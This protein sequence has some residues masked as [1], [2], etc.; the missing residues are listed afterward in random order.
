MPS[1]AVEQLADD[2]DAFWRRYRPCFRTRTRDTSDC[3]RTFWRGQLTMEDQRNF[4]NID[5]RLNRRDG[6]PLQHFMSESPWPSQPVY[7]QIQRDIRD[8]PTLQTGGLV[9]LDESADAK[10]GDQS[11]GAARQHNGRLGK[12]DLSQVA[13]CLAFA[14]PAT[15]T[16]ALVDGELFLPA[17]WFTQAYAARRRE[18]GLPPERTFATKPALGLAMIQRAQAHGLPFDTVACDEL[19]GRNRDLRAKFDAMHLNYAAQVPANTQV[20]LQEPQVGVPRRQGHGRQHT[21]LRVQSRHKPHTAYAVG[22]RSSMNWQ[23]VQVRHFERGILEAE[24]AVVRVWTL[25]PTM[26]VRAEWLV[27]R[28]DADGRMTYSLLNGAADTSTSTL[29]ERSCWRFYTERT[30]EDA[31]SEL[32]WDDFQARK[33]RAWEHEMALT[34]AA[35]WFVASI[36]L[37]WQTT[38]QRDPGLAKQFELE[39]LPALSTANVRDLL[40]TVLPVPQLTPESAR[41]LVVTHLV[42]RARSTSSRLRKQQERNDSS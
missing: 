7:E 36:K 39:V 34:A 6:Q 2:L 20:Y 19:Y 10:A 9:I 30:Y 22:R 40:M 31:K 11:V 29:I 33:Y 21:R 27:I 37:K 28:R 24:F 17:C 18:V 25:T 32:G 15:R 5:R 12:I 42:N 8:E 16:W 13:T 4:A 35:T 1:D 38:Y 41:Q 14:H 26:Q 3:A 23:R